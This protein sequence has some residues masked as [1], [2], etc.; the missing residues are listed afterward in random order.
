MSDR[1]N[2]RL[3]VPIAA[4][5]L[6]GFVLAGLLGGPR[7]AL[8][9]NLIHSLAACR[10]AHPGLTSLVIP[11]TNAGGAAG[12]IA[13]LI[14][15]MALLALQRQWTKAALFAGI[16]LGGRLVVE[17]LKL[18]VDRPRPS[19]DPHPVA[20]S[21][22]SF[23]S[24]HAANSMITL[25][26]VALLII[27]ARYR[28]MAVTAAISLSAAVG[29]TRPYLGV[30]WPSDVIGG[31]AFGTAWVVSLVAA[32]HYWLASDASRIG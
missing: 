30:H 27:P 26:T 23:P 6:I 14:L 12:M 18:A 17:L 20:V 1:A 21:S 25:L 10:A 24:A 22:L 15:I 11:L 4:I 19:F 3:P 29:L 5:A 9:V 7:A 32:S 8:D 2:I 13:I 16:V 28:G 31:W